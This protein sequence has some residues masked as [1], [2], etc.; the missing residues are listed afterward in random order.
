MEGA[1]ISARLERWKRVPVEHP[2]PE[3]LRKLEAAVASMPILRREIFLA[4]R[5][6]GMIY[7]L[8][9]AM[10]GCPALDRG[11]GVGCACHDRTRQPC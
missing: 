7:P 5:L 1:Y 10:A 11:G 9:R 2:D 6:D 4:M 3:T 8:T